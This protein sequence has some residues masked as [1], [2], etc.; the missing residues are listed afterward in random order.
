MRSGKQNAGS[1]TARRQSGTLRTPVESAEGSWSG[2]VDERSGR[3]RFGLKTKENRFV[4]V[5]ELIYPF[6]VWVFLSLHIDRREII[7]IRK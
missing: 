6:Q 3:G 2:R 5:F 1:G 4:F 7:N